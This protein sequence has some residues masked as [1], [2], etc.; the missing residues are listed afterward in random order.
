MSALTPPPGGDAV[1]ARRK[2]GVARG[3]L[4]A[5]R[6]VVIPN[7]LYFGDDSRAADSCDSAASR[8]ES[9]SPR[10]PNRHQTAGHQP[11]RT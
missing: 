4:L 1:N 10:S 11:T 5:L 8:A 6:L 7:M 2:G 3:A 9:G